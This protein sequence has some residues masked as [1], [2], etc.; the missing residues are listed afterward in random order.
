[1]LIEREKEQIKRNNKWQRL[2]KRKRGNGGMESA[3]MDSSAVGGGGDC[4]WV[5]QLSIY[6][7][8]RS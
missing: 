2:E 8:L 6:L 4:A 7:W 5:A 1:M 3:N